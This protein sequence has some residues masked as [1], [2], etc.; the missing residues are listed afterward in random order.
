MAQKETDA[1]WQAS[2]GDLK[3]GYEEDGL[4][5]TCLLCGEQ[6][7]KGIVYPK[8][9]VLY[10]AERFMRLHIEQAHGSVFAYLIGLNKKWTGLTDHQNHLLQL[11][12]EGK[13]DAEIQRE[14]GIGSASTIRNHRFVLKEKER[15][16]RIF[17]A[18]MELLKEKDTQAP[19]F[20]GVHR[21]ATIVDDRY[22]LT[23]DEN[24]ELL[25]K[26]FPEGVDG[27]LAKF[28]HKQKHKLVVLRQ[29]AQRFETGRTYPEQEV[30]AILEQAYPD[31]VTVRRYLIDYGFLDREEDGSAYWRKEQ[32]VAGQAPAAPDQPRK[33]RPKPQP[34]EPGIYQIRNTRNGKVLV[35]RTRGLKSMNGKRFE[36][37]LGAYANRELQREWNEYGEDAFAFEV[38]EKLEPKPEDPQEEKRALAELETKWL[39]DLQP[40]G[41]RG[42]HKAPAN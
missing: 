4:G 20:V 39:E 35:V 21:T 9:E 6:T 16:S 24:E 13:S 3:R 38:L 8:D 10:E 5:Y 2:L 41:E 30:N 17:L 19:A 42:Y 1:F 36:L 15:Q 22:N 25:R 11:F 18:L 37:R 7:E 34:A 14:T 26:F 23:E 29:L 27:T 12:Y 31:Y 40:Y 33:A 32:P 28:P